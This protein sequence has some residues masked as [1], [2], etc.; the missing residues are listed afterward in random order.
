MLNICNPQLINVTINNWPWHD[1]TRWLLVLFA[2][3]HFSL[4]LF[5]PFTP[6]ENMISS[7]QFRIFVNIFRLKT[8]YTSLSEGLLPL[9]DKL[10]VFLTM[11]VFNA[12]NWTSMMQHFSIFSYSPP[13]IYFASLLAFKLAFSTY[14]FYFYSFH[15]YM[16][17]F[18][19]IT[20]IFTIFSI[21][22]A[23]PFSCTRFDSARQTIAFTRNAVRA[24]L[25]E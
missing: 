11:V 24:V 19:F 23:F 22:F 20:F 5:L 12:T 13:H 15:T 25:L 10:F 2:S 14:R 1:M 8:F 4:C 6:S 16:Y 7:L 18:L 3:I 17:D 21:F 9:F